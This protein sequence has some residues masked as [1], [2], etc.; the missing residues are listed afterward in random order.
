MKRVVLAAV[1]LASG[2]IMP[3][4]LAS[5]DGSGNP[6][7]VKSQDGEWYDKQGVPTFKIDKDGKVDWFTYIGYLR[8]SSECLRCHGPDGLGST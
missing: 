7:P 4:R 1:L 8:Y 6:A 5:A 2:V 3:L